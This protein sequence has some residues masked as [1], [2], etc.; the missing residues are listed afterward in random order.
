MGL[1]PFALRYAQ[2]FPVLP[3]HGV[4]DDLFCTCGDPA[5]GRNTGKHPRIAG[6]LSNASRDLVTIREWFTRW[7]ESNL[8]LRCDDLVVVDVDGA[9]GHETWTTLIQ[10]H[11][12][13]RTVS[14]R[15]GSGGE[16]HLFRDTDPSRFVSRS[17]FL[18]GLDCKA[19]PGAYI[20]TQPSRHWSGGA[21][22]WCGR[23]PIA[24]LPGWLDEI[25]PKRLPDAPVVY[26]HATAPGTTE[27]GRVAL[28]GLVADMLA[29]RTPVGR[30]SGSRNDTLN[31][32]AYRAGR[33]VAGGGLDSDEAET[34]IV[35]AAIE[36]GLRPSEARRTWSSGFQAGLLLPAAVTA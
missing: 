30:E 25:L 32:V 20:V 34:A 24:A 27:Y 26:P 12:D 17:R 4:R 23:R 19:G 35:G 3:L 8:G 28:D 13:P 5:C 9:E 1:L 16:H 18:P 6:G 14:Q 29:A 2:R 15:T 33:L 7:P 10:E 11:G 31:A 21:Y 36:M 22:R